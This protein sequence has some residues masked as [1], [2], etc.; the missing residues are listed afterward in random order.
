[1]LLFAQDPPLGDVEAFLWVVAGILLSVAI[2]WAFLVM[3]P[4][5]A[6]QSFDVGKAWLC[7]CRHAAFAWQPLLASVLIGLLHFC[8][9]PFDK[10]PQSPTGTQRT[11]DWLP[12]GF[13]HY[14]DIH[15]KSLNAHA[16]D[17][18]GYTQYRSIDSQ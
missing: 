3:K 4:P 12:A 17:D 6:A 13:H 14:P 15:A 8:H 2:P 11:G 10:G 9:R 5:P 7:P 16:T 1:M 18:R